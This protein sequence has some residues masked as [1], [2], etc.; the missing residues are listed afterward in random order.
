M[1]KQFKREID[2][3]S[4]IFSFVHGFLKENGID[5]GFRYAFDLAL[6]ELFVNMIRYSRN[7]TNNVQIELL[8]D[9]EK[10]KAVLTDTDVDEYDI[11]QHKPYNKNQTLKERRNGGIGIHLVKEIMDDVSYE[12]R[13]RISRIILTKYLFKTSI[14]HQKCNPACAGLHFFLLVSV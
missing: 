3:L 12:Y 13:D 2:S 7:N 9:Q 6:E 5:N 14:S 10:L 1:K 11:N 8:V 4:A